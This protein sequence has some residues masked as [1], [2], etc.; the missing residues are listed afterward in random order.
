MAHQ[1][2]LRQALALPKISRFKL[3][4]QQFEILALRTEPADG[5]KDVLTILLRMTNNGPYPD[6]F[7]NLTTALQLVT[8]P[9]L[10]FRRYC[11]WSRLVQLST[12]N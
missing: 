2:T 9:L 4:G 7:V 8:R 3:G 6:G 5:N 11:F 10:R 1:S 12:P